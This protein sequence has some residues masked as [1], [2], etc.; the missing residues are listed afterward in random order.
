MEEAG[1]QKRPGDGWKTALFAVIFLATFLPYVVL[2]FLVSPLN[3]IFFVV[4]WV[5]FFSAACVLR[6]DDGGPVSGTRHFCFKT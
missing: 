3:M 6:V 1:E 5:A 2:F 4:A